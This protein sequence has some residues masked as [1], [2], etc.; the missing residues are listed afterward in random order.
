MCLEAV[1]SRNGTQAEKD[2][3]REDDPF[4]DD[5]F[6]FLRQWPPALRMA[7]PKGSVVLYD[8]RLLHQGSANG[9]EWSR[10]IVA[11]SPPP[12]PRVS[13]YFTFQSQE[14]T[15][16]GDRLEFEMDM[17]HSLLNKYRG[18]NTLTSL[19]TQGND[20][21]QPAT[22]GTISQ[23]YDSNPFISSE[24]QGPVNR[25]CRSCHSTCSECASTYDYVRDRCG[26]HD[27]TACKSGL[28]LQPG[29]DPEDPVMTHPNEAGRCVLSVKQLKR[30]RHSKEK[31][32]RPGFRSG[33]GSGGGEL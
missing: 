10:K 28:R 26:S 8:A 17:T 16:H 33:G 14:G 12:P 32:S 23:R 30:G 24:L 15:D 13:F 29:R 19:R 4:P 1:Q 18:L 31:F 3:C 22:N 2:A 21:K 27:C 11:S 6:P 20:S 25:G 5:P 9:L 7:L